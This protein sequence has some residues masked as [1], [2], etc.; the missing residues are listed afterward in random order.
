MYDFDEIIV[1][2]SRKID[3]LQKELNKFIYKEIIH[4]SRVKWS[5]ELGEKLLF[6]LFEAYYLY[7]DLLPEYVL[8]RYVNEKN[9]Q[10]NNK[11]LISPERLKKM[12]QDEKFFRIICD[13]VAGMTDYF[14][15]QKAL[16]LARLKKFEVSDLQLD[17]ALGRPIVME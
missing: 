13:Q 15:V 11:I 14:A 5:D 7:P 2:F 1:R 8:S 17:L 12:Q 10:S 3:P 16:R 9:E 4:Y 6:R